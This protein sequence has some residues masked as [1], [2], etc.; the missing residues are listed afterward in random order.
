MLERLPFL[1]NL[2]PTPTSIENTLLKLL[3]KS[4]WSPSCI[5]LCRCKRQMRETST[6]QVSLATPP[7]P[8][9]VTRR[10]PSP[11][12]LCSDQQLA[13]RQLRCQGDETSFCLLAASFF[14][15]IKVDQRF[16]CVALLQKRRS[17]SDIVESGQTNLYSTD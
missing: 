3:S 15:Q 9:V 7:F 16:R 8:L 2:T 6:V 14:C 11:G 10:L 13:V 17:L 4:A 1:P 5:S 12:P